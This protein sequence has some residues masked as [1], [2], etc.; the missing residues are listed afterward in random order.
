MKRFKYDSSKR[1]NLGVERELFLLKNGAIVPFASKVLES[2]QEGIRMNGSA[3]MHMPEPDAFGYELSASQLEMRAGPCRFERLGEQLLLREKELSC[4]LR[5]LQLEARHMEVAP[6]DM[7]L[8]VF[9]IPRYLEMV[10]NMPVET[11]RA[12][13]RV[14]GTHIHVGMENHEH[15]LA[16][17]NHAVPYTDKLCRLGDN[18]NGERLAIYTQMAPHAQPDTYRNWEAYYA[19][20]CE[21]DFVTDPRKCWT[22]IRISVHGT[23]EFRMFGATDSIDHILDWAHTCLEICDGV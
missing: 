21:R 8:D 15:A 5:P 7:P 1:R 11:L 2:M 6:A 23:I 12:A 17:Y 18:S 9:P 20:A 13:S 3:P 16:V 10:K 4:A 14:A 19:A 22:W